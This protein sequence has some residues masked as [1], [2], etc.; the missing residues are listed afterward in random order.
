M[1]DPTRMTEE[2]IYAQK[3]DNEAAGGLNMSDQQK[4]D[5]DAERERKIY[6]RYWVW[7]SYFNDKNSQKWLDTA[8][9]LKHI[10]VHVLQDIED[11]I[12]LKSFGK[13][14]PDKIRD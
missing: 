7:E 3:L 1:V 9:A 6:G 14:K 10:N 8:E 5:R 12:L 11:Y 13:E 4:A 2:Q